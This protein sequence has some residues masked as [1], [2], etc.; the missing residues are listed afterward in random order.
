VHGRPPFGHGDVSSA[1]ERLEHHEQVGRAVALV[2]VIGGGRAPGGRRDRRPG[3]LHQLLARLVETHH[4]ALGV[5]RPLIDLQHIFHRAD[6]VSVL[7]R[8]NHPLL[9]QPGLQRVFFSVSRTVSV[10]I[11]STTSNST[12]LSARSFK[13]QRARPSGGRLQAMA[14]SRA[15]FAPSSF[16][17]R[18]TDTG[19]R[20][21]AASNPSSTSPWR[22]RWIVDG[23]TSRASAISVSGK[24]SPSAS[25]FRT[26]RARRARSAATR[27]PES[28]ACKDRRSASV[29]R[30][31]YLAS[32]PT[33]RSF[34]KGGETERLS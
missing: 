17:G 26:I 15:S 12:S 24:A 14:I 31:T 6:K 9:L 23:P 3:L 19:R 32:L 5:V 20:N 34:S 28:N 7:I 11:E 13:V 8:G 29:N 30:T 2:L 10:A 21:S 1:T 25:A 18:P 33:G 16:G 4:G 27:L 22:R